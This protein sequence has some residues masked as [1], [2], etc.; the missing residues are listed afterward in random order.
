MAE[1]GTV[2]LSE[3]KPIGHIDFVKAEWKSAAS[4]L[5]IVH[6]AVDHQV[7]QFGVCLDLDKRVFI[8]ELDVGKD[9]HISDAELRDRTEA[10]WQI[11]ARARHT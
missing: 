1:I 5:A 9:Y 2:S 10:I 7:R 3:V 11:V 6:Y 8:D 4:H